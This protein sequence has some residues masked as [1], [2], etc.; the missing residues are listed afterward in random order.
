MKCAKTIT[1][2][3]MLYKTAVEYG[4]YTM[5][6][7]QGCAH[8]CKY[9]CYA[10][11][12]AKRFGKASSYD[13]W[14]Q[15]VLVSNTLELLDKEIP[16]LKGRIKHVQLCFT[17]DA[18]MYGYEDVREL[19]LNAIKRL[20]SDDIP[21]VV[22]SKGVLP[23]ELADLS[24]KNVYGITLVSLDEHYRERC[25]PGA[26]PYGERIHALKKLHDA[27]CRTW[28]SME[29]YPTP[30]VVEQ[31]LLP[32]LEQLS[33]ADKIIFGRTNYNK[34]VSS[35]PKVKEWYEDRVLEV[36]DF[37]SSHG[38]EYYIKK[39]TWRRNQSPAE[40][41]GIESVCGEDTCVEVDSNE[42]APV[43]TP[44]DLSLLN[45]VQRHVLEIVAQANGCLRTVDV[46]SAA[47]FRESETDRALVYLRNNGYVK[48]LG[49][50][51]HGVWTAGAS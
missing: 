27:G 2:K 39:G 51:K 20:N 46:I 13:E 26:A 7:V 15:P 24:R 22:L 8:G 40:V 36:V 32:I 31:E 28:V 45:E 35:Y 19:T 17:T 6:H 3:S 23:I 1:R 9:P 5:N 50:K 49:T 43:F 29:P 25:E 14:C 47:G 44:A 37:C 38:I 41:L 30:N 34:V 33:F 4:D 16:R 18:F 11:Q 42:D 10:M 12:M 48:C 21:C